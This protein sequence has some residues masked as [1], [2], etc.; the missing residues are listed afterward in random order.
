MGAGIGI[1]CGVLAW[2]LIAALGLGAV[3]AVSELAFG[4]LQLA[5]A[6][7]LIWLGLGLLWRA[8]R[9]VAIGPGGRRPSGGSGGAHALASPRSADQPAQ[10]QGRRVLCQ[11]PA[12][13]HPGRS[14]RGRVQILLAAIHAAMGVAW[15][16]LLT[17]ATRPFARALRRPAVTRSLDGVT[18][19]VL[20]GFGVRLALDRRIG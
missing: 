5:G 2:G 13:V 9:P 7:Y 1:C 19:A 14:G 16:G 4:V 15:F 6:A 11:L 3:L 10:P 17:A 8:E 12:A 18:G 20:V